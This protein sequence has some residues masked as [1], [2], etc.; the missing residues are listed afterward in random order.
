[1]SVIELFSHSNNGIRIL[2]FGLGS[3]E[4]RTQYKLPVV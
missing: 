1:V 4:M 3:T 2:E